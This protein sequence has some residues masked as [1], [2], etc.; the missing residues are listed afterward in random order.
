MVK[1]GV[2]V[3]HVAT[4]R[5][6]RKTDEPDP[7]VA[8]IMSELAGADG[9]VAHLRGDRRHIQDRDLLLLREVVRTHLNLEMAASEAMVKIALDLKPDMVTLV[10]EEPNEVTTEG[11]LNV[12]QSY[13]TL[14]ETIPPLRD[15]GIVV[16]LFVDPDVN[17]IKAAAK[18]RADYVEIHTGLYAE[19]K[20]AS[21]ELAELEKIQ[22]VAAVAAKLGFGVSAGHGLTYQNVRP[23]AE[24]KE[25]EELNIGHTIVSRAIM[26]GMEQAVR[27]MISLIR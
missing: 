18:L 22:D 21:E 15:E 20:D 7:V 5:Q 23:I 17:Q 6:A 10:P 25:V 26:A 24:I 11:G 4:V 8:A 9:I 12:L 13:Q 2:N 16:S 27:E 1:L 19:A 3:D 14:S